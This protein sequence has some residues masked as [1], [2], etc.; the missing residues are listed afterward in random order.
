MR[1]DE[2]W[3]PIRETIHDSKDEARH[4]AEYEYAGVARTWIMG[5]G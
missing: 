2:D 3:D 1:C 5:E 4:Q